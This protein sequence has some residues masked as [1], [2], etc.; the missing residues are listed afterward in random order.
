MRPL[1]RPAGSSCTTTLPMRKRES[2]MVSVGSSEREIRRMEIFAGFLRVIILRAGFGEDIF[3]RIQ[4][5]GFSEGRRRIADRRIH[6]DGE[7]SWRRKDTGEPPGDHWR[8]QN[9]AR[10]G[11]AWRQFRG[12][13]MG[14]GIGVAEAR[15]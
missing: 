6:D 13:R 9:R 10:R 12:P 8:A 15:C 4:R 2:P 5:T 3:K 1:T 14:R 7:E 11:G